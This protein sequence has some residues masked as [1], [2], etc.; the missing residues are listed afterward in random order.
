MTRAEAQTMNACVGPASPAKRRLGPGPYLAVAAIW[1]ALAHVA[2]SVKSVEPIYLWIMAQSLLL[3]KIPGS[4]RWSTEIAWLTAYAGI[5]MLAWGIVERHGAGRT[6]WWRRAA[7]AW[8]AIQLGFG[9]FA[10]L[11]FH[12]GVLYE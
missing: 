4:A 9:V 1:L 5:A 7:I 12:F 11:L 8:L 3:E 6:H 10:A 2:A